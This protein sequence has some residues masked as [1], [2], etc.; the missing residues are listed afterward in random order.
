MARKLIRDE[1]IQSRVTA[2]EKKILQEYADSQGISL[3]DLVRR[4]MAALVHLVLSQQE[5]KHQ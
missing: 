2:R 4:S 1:V 5:Q 3:S